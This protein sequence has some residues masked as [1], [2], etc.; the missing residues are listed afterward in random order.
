M[1]SAEITKI[2]KTHLQDLEKLHLRVDTSNVLGLIL[3]TQVGDVLNASRQIIE[4]LAKVPMHPRELTTFTDYYYP[5]TIKLVRTAVEMT[6]L[7][8]TT[9][10]SDAILN[11][12]R[13]VMD[14]I[15]DAFQKQLDIMFDEMRIDI[16][17]DIEVLKQVLVSDGL[18]VN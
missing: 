2:F 18:K 1:N 6:E 12:I 9:D 14:T 15:V 3:N 16:K 8:Q 5:T 10:T 17:T 13:G 11:K 4:K 7:H